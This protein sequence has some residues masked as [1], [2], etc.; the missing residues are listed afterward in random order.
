MNEIISTIITGLPFILLAFL[1]IGLLYLYFILIKWAWKSRRD[2][3]LTFLIL[4][5]LCL[6]PSLIAYLVEALI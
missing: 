1:S 3:V 5:P 2:W 6:F 4:I